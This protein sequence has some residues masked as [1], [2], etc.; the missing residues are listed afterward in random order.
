MAVQEELAFL[1]NG[2]LGAFKM[3]CIVRLLSQDSWGLGTLWPEIKHKIS[4]TSN[5]LMPHC[6]EK[7]KRCY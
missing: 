3:F 5:E 7:Y 4:I 2:V 6:K 1:G